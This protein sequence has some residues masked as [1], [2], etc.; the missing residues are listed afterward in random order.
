M[1]LKD[2]C[3]V[4]HSCNESGNA[5]AHINDIIKGDT[6][7]PLSTIDSCILRDIDIPILRFTFPEYPEAECL[8][9]KDLYVEANLEIEGN[10]Y[11]DDVQDLSLKVKG[12]GNSTWNM[13]KKPMRL[14]FPKKLP[15]AV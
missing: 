7:I 11:C 14:K 13:P 10:G 15:Y 1:T 8:W 6:Q 12:R 2:K 9:N 4:T 3:Y 5:T